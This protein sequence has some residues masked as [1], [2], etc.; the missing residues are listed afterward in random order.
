MEYPTDALKLD[1]RY[2]RRTERR[3]KFTEGL[4]DARKVDTSPWDAWKV[5]G[6]L[7][8]VPRTHGMLTE[9]DG[10]YHGRTES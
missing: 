1:G 3:Q 6:N 7:R 5:D 8:T 10:K 4:V 9:V 2:R